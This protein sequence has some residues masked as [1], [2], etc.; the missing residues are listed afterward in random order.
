MSEDLLTLAAT[1]AANGATELRLTPWRAILIPVPSL[2]AARVLAAGLNPR[3]FILNGND[4]RR[5][6]AACPGAPSC[7]TAT[8]NARDDATRLACVL[9]AVIGPGI[10]L[11]VSG[12]TKGCA[13][14]ARAPFTLVGHEG[15]YDFIRDGI[16]SD[17]PALRGLT[18]DQA[19][20][21][22]RDLCADPPPGDAA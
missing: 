2:D 1:A 19:A 4:P 10:T 8:V 3:S 11:H 16:A 13:H 6:V 12:C 18:L 7:A 21:L 15:H 5:H 22:L 17:T 9:P 14:P 20:S